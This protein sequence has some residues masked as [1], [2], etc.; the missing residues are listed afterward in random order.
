MVA[1][2]G[3]ARVY[4]CEANPMLAAS[5][6]A[7]I[8]ANGLADRITVFDRHS[9]GFDRVHD[10]GGGVDLVVSEVFCHKLIGEGVLG[11]LAHA[12]GELAAPG[13]LFLPERASMEVA[14]A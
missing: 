2:A 3:A 11:S 5:A 12:C 6:R 9:T 7:V 1:R 8:A 14:L 10:L 13:A 4:A